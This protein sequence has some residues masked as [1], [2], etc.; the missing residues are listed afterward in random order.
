MIRPKSIGEAT[1]IIAQMEA[2]NAELQVVVD[3]VTDFLKSRMKKD[4]KNDFGRKN[5]AELALDCMYHSAAKHKTPGAGN[6]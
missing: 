5:T 2:R 6:E 4:L 3:S 1:R